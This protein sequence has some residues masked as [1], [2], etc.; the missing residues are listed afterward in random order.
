PWPE[1]ARGGLVR[2][3]AAGRP[4]IPVLEALDQKGLLVRILPEWEPVRSRPQRNAYHRFTVD[5]HLCEAAAEAAGLAPRVRRPDLLVLGTWLHDIGKGTPEAGDHSKVGADLVE[6]MARRMGF[7]P[8]D[9]AVLV[10]LV[11]H[12][13]LLAET[14]TRRDLDD[15]ETLETVARALGDVETLELMHA[16]TEA[17][18]LATGPVAWT[19]WKAGLVA[20]LVARVRA[21]L[22]GG[23]PETTAFPSASQLR[24]ADGV[25]TRGQPLVE[26]SGTLLTVAAPDRP[27]LFCQVAGTLTLH[28]LDVLAARAWSDD[29]GVAVEDFRVEPLFGGEPDWNRFEHDLKQALGRPLWLQARLAERAR[30]YARRS[31]PKAARPP[32]T[33][34][35]VDNDASRAATVVEVRAPDRLGTLYSITRALAELRLD[36][37]HAKV[38]TLGHEVVDVFYVVDASGGKVDDRKG[39]ANIERAVLSELSHL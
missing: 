4:A 21:L 31:G 19:P 24:L 11:R 8:D 38:T 17:D 36:I 9:V 20:D 25:R 39:A 34:V 22:E 13:L 33:A 7:P 28:G 12:H 32:R 23:T 3:L 35:R 14:A 5:R 37:R 26:G 30:A 16:L 10:A 15:P 6:A 1:E 2:L 18:G 27:G 29:G